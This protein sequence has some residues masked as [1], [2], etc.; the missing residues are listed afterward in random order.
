MGEREGVSL[1][2]Q[3]GVVIIT[4]V[5]QFTRALHAQSTPVQRVWEMVDLLK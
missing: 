1:Q 4:C 3:F 2:S 5:F